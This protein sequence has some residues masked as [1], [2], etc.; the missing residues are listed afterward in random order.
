MFNVLQLYYQISR[1]KNAWSATPSEIDDGSG[2]EGAAKFKEKVRHVGP[3]RKE[4]VHFVR[5]LS[6]LC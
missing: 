4:V 3:C 1:G 2:P 5:Y 6:T